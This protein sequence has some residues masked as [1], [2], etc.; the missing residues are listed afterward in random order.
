MSNPLDSLHK[1]IED[2]QSLPKTE[3]K[4][5]DTF[6]L[7]KLDPISQI[8]HKIFTE[9]EKLNQQL[10]SKDLGY[11]TTSFLSENK[12]FQ[13]HGGV[14]SKVKIFQGYIN[15]RDQNNKKP[16]SKKKSRE[17]LSNNDLNCYLK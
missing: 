8:L 6:S 9:L 17:D 15:Q 12:T 11:T 5:S 4:A 16:F 2:L 10:S 13:K 3:K 1:I 7:H 14:S